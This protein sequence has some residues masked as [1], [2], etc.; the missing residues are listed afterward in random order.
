[1]RAVESKVTADDIIKE[2]MVSSKSA[3]KATPSFT[4]EKNSDTGGG[5]V[6]ATGRYRELVTLPD[7]DSFVFVDDGSGNPVYTLENLV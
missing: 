6:V 2:L 7:G 4:P 5:S 3:S 1:M